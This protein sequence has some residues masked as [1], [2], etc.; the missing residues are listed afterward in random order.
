MEAKQIHIYH[1]IAREN[2][3]DN[4]F[5]I[6]ALVQP[7]CIRGSMSMAEYLISETDRL[8]MGIPDTLEIDSAQHR[9][10]TIFS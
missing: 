6:R 1:A 2:Q 5:F 8:V 7:G 3:L 10:A 9:T 4:R